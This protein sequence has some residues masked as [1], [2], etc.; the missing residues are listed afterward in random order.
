MGRYAEGTVATESRSKD[1]IER[2]LR[3]YGATELVTGWSEAADNPAILVEFS[4]H[5]RRIRLQLPIAPKPLRP[6]QEWRRDAQK[7]RQAA[8]EAER[9]R[10]WRV[11]L[12]WLKTQLELVESQV[13]GFEDA[14]LANMLLP[15]GQT[16]SEWI[17]PQIASAYG[18]GEMPK[19]LPAGQ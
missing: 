18:R 1:E 4:M 6:E 12:I 16:V 19:L 9:R 14:F 15:G 2:T 13:I 3:R 17:Q 7:L 8:F 10:I 11:A 5:R